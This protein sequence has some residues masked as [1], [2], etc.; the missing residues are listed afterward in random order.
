MAAEFHPNWSACKQGARRLHA[1][2]CHQIL[3]LDLKTPVDFVVC[4]TP[5]AN[6]S[7]GT[8]Q[9]LRIA[10]RLNIPIF[11]YGDPR[12]PEY[13][14]QNLILFVSMLAAEL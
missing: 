6:R 8:G 4:Y 3:G 7:G 13:A 14:E 10:E 1:R 12:G 11:D 2:N 5:N 9:A